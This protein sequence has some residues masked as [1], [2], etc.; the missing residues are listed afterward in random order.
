MKQYQTAKELQH[1][2]TVVGLS[3]LPVDDF[4]I[5]V[6]PDDSEN[7]ANVKSGLRQRIARQINCDVILSAIAL[8]KESKA[9]C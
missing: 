7:E 3:R 2:V 4:E 1:T 8:L 5:V 6:E 9:V